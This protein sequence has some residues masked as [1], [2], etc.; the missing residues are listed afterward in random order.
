MRISEL[1][2]AVLCEHIRGAREP[3][4]FS[5]QLAIIQSL[6][7]SLSIS[8][9]VLTNSWISA[10]FDIPNEREAIVNI[11]L[12]KGWRFLLTLSLYPEKP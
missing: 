10:L 8:P 2:W 11:S 9:E 1:A 6:D 3:P 4:F 5:S 7:T 12:V